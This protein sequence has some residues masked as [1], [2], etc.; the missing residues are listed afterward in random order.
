MMFL[1]LGKRR[2]EMDRGLS[3]RYGYTAI[4]RT[5]QVN[6]GHSQWQKRGE[7]GMSYYYKTCQ[8][9]RTGGYTPFPLFFFVYRE[10][11]WEL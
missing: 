8:D 3:T 10:K 2:A 9:G 11:A 4:Q 6:S 5:R 7:K 1:F